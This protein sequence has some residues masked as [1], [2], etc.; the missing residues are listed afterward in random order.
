M[1]GC[2]EK[3]WERIRSYLKKVFWPN[4]GVGFGF[5]IPDIPAYACGLKPEPAY[6]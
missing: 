3:P 2:E 6:I 1:H 5:Q 4:L